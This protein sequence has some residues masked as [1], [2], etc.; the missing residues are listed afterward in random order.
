[1]TVKPAKLGSNLAKIVLVIEFDGTNYC[2][3]QFQENAPTIQDEIEK[4]IKR[5]TGEGLRIMGAS[6]TDSG[7]H[8]KAQVVCFRTGSG[9]KPEVFLRGLN[10]FLPPDIAVKESYQVNND[11]NV[12]REAIGRRY[13]YLIFNSA[14][15]SPLNLRYAHQVPG[16]LNLDSMNEACRMLLGEHD[17]VSFV[18]D[19][20]ESD[21]KSTKRTVFSARVDARED[22]VTFSIEANAFLPHQVRN[23]VGTLVRVGLGKIGSDDFKRI[24]EAKKPGLAGPTVPAQGLYLMQ[25]KYPRPLGEYHE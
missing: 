10:H 23:T 2:G 9:Y 16:M 3:F 15:R 21:L 20:A 22:W 7:V 6:R 12:Q 14:V 18:T 4:A 11:F 19:L 13:H 25:V 24:L 1:L 5:L 17:L 8:A